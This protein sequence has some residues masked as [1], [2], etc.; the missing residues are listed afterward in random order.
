MRA[1]T[2]LR[3]RRLL[4]SR[5]DL[6]S[7]PPPRYKSSVYS[8][9]FLS[10]QNTTYPPSMSKSSN[11]SL[12]L[13]PPYPSLYSLLISSSLFS[14]TRR[15]TFAQ[16]NQVGPPQCT[17]TCTPLCKQGALECKCVHFQRWSI[18]SSSSNPQIANLNTWGVTHFSVTNE[19]FPAGVLFLAASCY[20][21]YT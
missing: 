17:P 18:S 12:N 20:E 11:I 13:C 14:S 21:W 15:S 6:L 3:Y 19:N 4:L 16:C 7:L 2:Y 5:H 8:L 10:A 1:S 9:S